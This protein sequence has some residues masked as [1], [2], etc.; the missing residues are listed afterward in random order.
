MSLARPAP[1]SYVWASGGPPDDSFTLDVA[2]PEPG[3]LVL[4]ATAL[5]G[6]GAIGWS[7][8]RA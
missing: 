5:I 7:R 2:V 4:L 6:L 8:R 1:G 3:P